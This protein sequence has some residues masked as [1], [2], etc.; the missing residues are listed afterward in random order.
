MK[1]KIKPFFLKFY[2]NMFTMKFKR[3]VFLKAKKS[4]KLSGYIKFQKIELSLI[5]KKKTYSTQR[6]FSFFK[7]KICRFSVLV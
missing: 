3:F 1:L 2:I 5:F 4:L 6:N 7:I